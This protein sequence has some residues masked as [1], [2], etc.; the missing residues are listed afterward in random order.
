MPYFSCVR[1]ARKVSK[2]SEE[3]IR[4]KELVVKSGE[5]VHIRLTVKMLCC[6]KRDVLNIYLVPT[7]DPER[8]IVLY[9]LE[10]HNEAYIR[11]LDVPEGDIVQAIKEAVDAVQIT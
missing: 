10:S 9:E 3:Y 8:F 1:D 4:V 11:E 6:D 5:Y 7:D 2:D